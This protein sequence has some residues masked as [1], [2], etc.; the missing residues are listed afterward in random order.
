[1][2]KARVIKPHR[3]LYAD[4]MARVGEI[5]ELTDEVAKKL[6]EIGL[7]EIVNVET[8]ENPRKKKKSRKK[9]K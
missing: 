7:I 8:E 2:V 5:I 6:E 1:M 4:R 9:R 3:L